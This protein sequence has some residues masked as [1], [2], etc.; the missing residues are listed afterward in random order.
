MRLWILIFVLLIPSMGTSQI[1]LESSDGDDLALNIFGV[2]RDIWAAKVNAASTSFQV[3]YLHAWSQNGDEPSPPK[4]FQM[5]IRAKPSDGVAE[6]FSEGDFK[7]NVRINLGLTRQY[8]L[9]K[10]D[11]NS[12]FNDFGTVRLDYNFNR[13]AVFNPDTTFSNQL[14]KFNFNSLALTFRYNIL[15]NST[16]LFTL[17]SG[18]S[19]QS[20]YSDLDK[21]SVN[22]FSTIIDS[23]TMTTREYGTTTSARIGN[24]VERRVIPVTIAYSFLPSLNE[25]DSTKLA[26]GG[27]IYY[28]GEFGQFIPNHR[29]GGVLYITKQNKKSGIRFPILGIGVQATNLGQITNIEYELLENISLTLTSTFDLPT[30]LRR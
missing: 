24:Y 13:Y 15:V 5:S 25:E 4:Y 18:L 21:I 16:Q 1:L 3:N 10:R 6:F 29:L 30:F 19:N 27:T 11:P 26:I 22:S 28:S 2:D 20:N 12:K 9:S 8:I 14:R 7:P 17:V 23:S